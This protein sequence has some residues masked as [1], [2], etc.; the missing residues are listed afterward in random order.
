[1]PDQRVVLIT[2]A[3]SG[4]GQSTARLLSQRGNRQVGAKRMTEY[5]PWRQRAFNAIRAQEEN[6]PGPELVVETV[7]EIISSK[8][9]RLRYLIGQQAKSVARLRRFLPAGL[10]EQGV[11]RTFSLDKTP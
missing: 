6:A 3:S 10:Y 11:R 5:D 8:T 7:L 1:M 4:V 2:G 9:P